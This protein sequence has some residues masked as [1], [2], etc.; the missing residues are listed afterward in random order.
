MELF[1]DPKVDWLGMSRILI[2][3]SLAL[4]L[5]GAGSMLLRGG[6]RLGVDFVGGTLAYVKF[7]DDP[8]LDRIRRTLSEGDLEGRGGDALR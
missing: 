7:K 6:L 3:V 2:A 5:L 4:A 1:K 8:E